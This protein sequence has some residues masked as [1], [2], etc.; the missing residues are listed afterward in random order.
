M[1][2][3]RWA[4]AA[5]LLLLVA[6]GVYLAARALD[7]INGSVG[8]VRP[9]GEGEQEVAYIEPATNV[10]DWER[11]VSALTHLRDDW[12]SLYPGRPALHVDLE[13]AFPSLTADVPEVALTFDGAAGQ[14]LWVR[15]YKV[16]GGTNARARVEQLRRR[17]RPPIAVLGGGTSGRAIRLARSLTEAADKG[18][19]GT[20][21]IFLI[22]TATA[23]IARRAGGMKV[24][25][26]YPGRSF[27]FAF[28]NGTMVETVLRF[29][30]QQPQVWLHRA[31]DPA[32]L[33][34]AT[35]LGDPWAG[36]GVL[37]AAGALTPPSLYTVHWEDDS[38][39]RDL[40]DAFRTEFRQRFPGAEPHDRGGL[41]YSVGDFYHPNPAEQA[42]VGTLVADHAPFPPHSL[43]VLPTGAQ[44]MRRFLGNLRSRAPLEARH[45]VVVNGDAISFTT[46]Y[47]DRDYAWNVQDLPFNLVFFAHRDPIDPATGFTWT[48]RH[49]GRSRTGTTELLLSR[50]IL[51]AVLHATFA[52]GRLLDDAD[53]VRDRLRQSVWVAGSDAPMGTV[54]AGNRVYNALELP[55]TVTGGRD[56]FDAQGN[57]RRYTGEHIVWLRPSYSGDRLD[58]VSTISV[59]EVEPPDHAIGRPCAWRLRGAHAAT[60]NQSR[61]EED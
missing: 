1:R 37:L 46:V 12:P 18:W 35:T 29:V 50:D 26:L 32:A 39:S 4:L 3:L 48:G 15:W 7:L 51:E 47:R 34:G 23:E 27:R 54:E 21:P 16:S 19:D 42:A 17:G 45:L 44:R 5:G 25:D 30:R 61:P 11:I 31:A 52:D 41:P 57:R 49:G 28:T 40:A 60:Y 36:L 22:T 59:W 58:L 14:T 53:R 6:G 9:L 56:L 8:Q 10:E 24:M 20:P 33:A 38:Y 2:P 43:L 55:P 13:R